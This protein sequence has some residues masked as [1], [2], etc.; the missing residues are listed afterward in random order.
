[1]MGSAM[2]PI[3]LVLLIVLHQC[4]SSAQ[5]IVGSGIDCEET[6]SCNENVTCIDSYY[7]LEMYIKGNRE[8]IEGL[9][10]AFLSTGDAPSKFVKLLY[11]F[12]VSNLINDTAELFGNCTHKTSKYIWSDSALYLLGPGMLASFTFFAVDIP[13]ITAT[14]DLPCLCY[15]EYDSLL[16]RLTYM[17]CRLS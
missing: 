9:K 13:E 14:I 7:D 1:M 4:F 17:V 6:A 8:V 15:D 3:L 2:A 10:S 5:E 12:R 16:S 11:H